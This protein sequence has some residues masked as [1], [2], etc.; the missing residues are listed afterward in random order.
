MLLNF[1]AFLLSALLSSSAAAATY[2]ASISAMHQEAWETVCIYKA[3]NCSELPAPQVWYTP[4]ADGMFGY[5]TFGE[6]GI[7]VHLKLLGDPFSRYVVIHEMVHYIQLKQAQTGKTG[8][9]YAHSCVRESEAFNITATAAYAE[10]FLDPRLVTWAR[11]RGHY[12]CGPVKI[13][14]HADRY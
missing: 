9:L 12:G 13:G 14:W 3:V 4:D 11:A 8:V 1:A 5:Y 7:H 10:R 2:L 6:E